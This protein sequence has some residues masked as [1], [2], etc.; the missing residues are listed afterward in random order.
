MLLALL[1][2]FFFVHFFPSGV[3]SVPGADQTKERWSREK[4]ES[5]QADVYVYK[6]GTGNPR[7][8]H[9]AQ[10]KVEEDMLT[11]REDDGSCMSSS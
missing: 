8:K 1:L 9:H 2:L 11:T 10:G 3:G 7:E 5:R 4:K 6:R